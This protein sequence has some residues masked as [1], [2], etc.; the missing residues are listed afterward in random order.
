MFSCT[1]GTCVDDHKFTVHMSFRV[2]LYDKNTCFMDVR[3]L[4][5]MV[6]GG[7]HDRYWGTW[8]DGL[9]HILAI[10]YKKILNF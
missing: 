3:D 1:M 10:F 7:G 9:Q 8:E 4:Q 2:P 5:A 6:R